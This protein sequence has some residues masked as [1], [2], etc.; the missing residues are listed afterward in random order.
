M[1][2]PFDRSSRPLETQKTYG[3]EAGRNPWN[4]C[5]ELPRIKGS[6]IVLPI[7]LNMSFFPD[8]SRRFCEDRRFRRWFRHCGL[9]RILIG[10]QLCQLLNLPQGDWRGT[11]QNRME[12]FIQTNG[13]EFHGCHWNIWC[14]MTFQWEFM[15]PKMEVLYH[16]RPYFVGIFPYIGL[17]QA[18]YIVGTSNL[19]SWNGHWTFVG[20]KKHIHTTICR[21]S[22]SN[23]CR[24]L[25]C[26]VHEFHPMPDPR[27][28]RLRITCLIWVWVK[29]CTHW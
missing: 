8:V 13:Q 11:N 28:A 15:D 10:S 27:W 9:P 17:T 7:G 12:F 20:S 29:P 14:L 26:W 18:L 1:F 23:D 3:Q 24:S 5:Q 25:L 2:I 4:P 21:R 6:R 22:V 19:G 16:I